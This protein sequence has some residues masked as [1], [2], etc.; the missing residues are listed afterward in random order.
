MNDIALWIR[1]FQFNLRHFHPNSSD[2]GNFCDNNAGFN[3]GELDIK[4][5]LPTYLQEGEFKDLVGD[6]SDSLQVALFEM[7]TESEPLKEVFKSNYEVSKHVFAKLG[8]NFRFLLNSKLKPLSKDF[9]CTLTLL[10]QTFAE[11]EIWLF[12]HHFCSIIWVTYRENFRSVDNSKLLNSDVG[13]GCTIRVGQMLLLSVLKRHLGVPDWNLIWKI[14]ENLESAPYSLHKIVKIGSFFGKKPGDWYSPSSIG[15]VL[16]QLLEESPIDRLKSYISMNCVIYKDTL[17]AMALGI[18]LEQSK[19][20][21][22]C[23]PNE[24]I[25]LGDVCSSCNQQIISRKWENSLFVQLPIML[26]M[27]FLMD[28]YVETLKF[29]LSLRQIAGIVGGKP[30]M[31]LFIVGY[32]ENQFIVLDPHLVQNSPRSELE[33][34]KMLT[35][36]HCKTPM[37]LDFSEI[38]SSFNIGFYF[39]DEESWLEFEWK[40]KN[41]ARVKGVISISEHDHDE[42]SDVIEVDFNS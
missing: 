27:E 32:S 37:I 8:T 14:Q 10:G 24:Y 1:N 5:M 2:N 28:E 9:S 6:A 13:W 23:I 39:E 19:T 21:C 7:Q 16:T 36:Y 22:R 20:M 31:A 25:D 4:Y 18:P 11:S 41:D 40:I 26:G 35:S 29:F 30:R 12:M 17:Y 3:I 34:K 15:F 38:E 33:F 42:T